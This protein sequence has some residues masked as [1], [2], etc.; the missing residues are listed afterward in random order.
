MEARGV[1][2]VHE[3]EPEVLE[4]DKTVNQV[5]DAVNSIEH[6]DPESDSDDE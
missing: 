5:Y 2:T 4:R 3:E 1:G 6:F